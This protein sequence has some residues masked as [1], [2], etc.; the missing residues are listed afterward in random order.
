MPLNF[1][2]TRLLQVF[3]CDRKELGELFV[4]YD[5]AY[6]EG[7]YELPKGKLIVLLLQSLNGVIFDPLWTTIRRWTP[8]KEKYYREIIGKEVDIIVNEV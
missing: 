8:Q 2:E 6:N 3:I 4:N 5:T 1:N 7:F